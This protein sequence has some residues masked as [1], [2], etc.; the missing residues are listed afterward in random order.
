MNVE[1]VGEVFQQLNKANLNSLKEVYH[2]DVV[3]EDA[4]H[5]IEGWSNLEQYFE[6]LYANVIQCDF[7]IE[8][9][10]QTGDSGFLVWLM[11]L[12]HPKLNRGEVVQVRGIS[13]LKLNQDK[14]IY[15]RDYFDLGEML[16][17]HIPVLGAIIKSIKRKLGS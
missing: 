10:H 8:E 17:E 4:A 6:N 15:H 2:Q 9:T 12:R 7:S 14:V 1:S 16:Y 13:H 5:R 11:S 3:F